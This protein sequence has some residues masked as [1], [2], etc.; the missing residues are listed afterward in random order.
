MGIGLGNGD[1][2]LINQQN[3]R[4]PVMLLHHTGK[5]EQGVFQFQWIGNSRSDFGKCILIIC[6]ESGAVQK[7]AVFLIKLADHSRQHIR[8]F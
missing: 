6:I 5:K 7:I 1:I 8:G 3:D 4:F 2:I